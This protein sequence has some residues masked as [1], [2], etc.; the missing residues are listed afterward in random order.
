MLI[1]KNT[2][3]R[4]GNDSWLKDHIHLHHNDIGLY[5]DHKKR[6]N[7]W[8]GNISENHT[9]ELDEFDLEKSQKLINDYIEDNSLY[10]KFPNGSEEGIIINL[11]ELIK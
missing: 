10:I 2:Y 7:G 5:L 9:L 11:I 1:Y 8:N 4:E 3:E 6:W